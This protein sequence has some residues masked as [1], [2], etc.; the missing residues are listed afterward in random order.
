MHP[1]RVQEWLD[2]GTTL[3][4][5]F[6]MDPTNYCIR[7]CEDCSGNRFSN[8]ELSYDFMGSIIDQIDSFAKGIIYTGGG[9]PLLNRDTTK[10]IKYTRKRG[11]HPAL[12]TNGLLIN[13]ESANVM[14]DNCVYVRV[15]VPRKCFDNN[16]SLFDVWGKIELLSKKKQKNNSQCS[17]GLGYLTNRQTQDKMFDVA[18]RAKDVGLDYV[19]F[20]PFHFDD[21]YLLREIDDIKNL[22]EN[23]NFQVIATRFKYQNMIEHSPI[24]DEMTECYRDHFSTVIAADGNL[25]PCCYTRG[26]NEF[27]LGD[28]N[29]KQFN[30]IWYSDAKQKVFREKLKKPRCP[31]MCREDKLN[32]ILWEIKKGQNVDYNDSGHSSFI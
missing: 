12:V 10:A 16:S 30:E 24:E 1:A 18:Q 13:E 6:Q 20:R 5:T 22:L 15:S 17:L 7:N 29:E 31:L 4:I 11:I 3:P 2:T 26:M 32:Q 28:L 27:S 21:T 14:T 19:Q 25:Y 9:E 8:S 23:E